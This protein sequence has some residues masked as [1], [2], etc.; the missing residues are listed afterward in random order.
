MEM[1]SANNKLKTTSSTQI[2]LY[3]FLRNH[4]HCSKWVLKF[5]V[6][7]LRIN[8]FTFQLFALSKTLQEGLSDI[9]ETFNICDENTYKIYQ[10]YF[11]NT[12]NSF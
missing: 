7:D 11:L 8:K 12:F 4:K 1:S 5:L 2:D 3:T 10:K 9:F 6:A